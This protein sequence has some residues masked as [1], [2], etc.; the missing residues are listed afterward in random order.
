MTVGESLGGY[1]ELKAT[2]LKSLDDLVFGFVGND[3]V[4]REVSRDEKDR[5]FRS[6][7]YTI[8]A[9]ERRTFPP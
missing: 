4:V 9:G 7:L 5:T 3:D 2:V 1:F 8:Q 6:A